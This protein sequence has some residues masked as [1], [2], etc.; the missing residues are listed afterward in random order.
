MPRPYYYILDDQGN[1]VPEPD[2]VKF[3]IWYEKTDRTVAHDEINGAIVSTVF[4]AQ[5]HLYQYGD[6]PPQLYETMIFGV[7]NLGYQKRYATRAEALTGH[8]R[9]L[10]VVRK[11]SSNKGAAP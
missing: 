11:L 5:D 6:G 10:D 3:S 7:E 8:Q 2:F 4:L 9:A 1:P